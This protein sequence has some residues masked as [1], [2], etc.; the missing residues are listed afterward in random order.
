[1]IARAFHSCLVLA[2]GLEL[3]LSGVSWAAPITIVNMDGF[4]EGFNDSSPRSSIGGNPGTTLGAQRLY[5]FNHA[6]AIWSGILQNAVE[7]RVEARFDPQFCTATSAVL[8]S[9]GPVT[10]DIDFPG[11]EVADTWYVQALANKLAGTDRDPSN[12]DIGATFNSDVDNG[13]CLGSRDWYYG[14]DG[15]EGNHIELLP[16]VL[17]EIAHGLGFLTLV[18]GGNGTEFFGS[19]DIYERFMFDLS[20]DKHWP[21]MNDAERAASALNGGSLVWDGP[22]VTFRAQF[23]LA[24][25]A[26][27][28]VN[29]PPAIAGTRALGRASF[30]T[31]IG[32]PG[33]TR[34]V[35]LAND[36]SGV[37]SDACSALLNAAQ[38]S[39]K[40][41]LV[42][43]ST[44]CSDLQ[45]ATNVQAAGG[46]GIMIV[47]SVA[48]GTPPT[49]RGTDP[50][51]TLVA[52]GLKLADGNALRGELGNGVNVTMGEDPAHLSGAAD[53]GRV[54]LFAPNP[55]Q[56]GSSLSHWD[57]TAYPNLLMEPAI[58]ANLSSDVDLT[59]EH[60]EDIG[61]LPDVT[62]VGRPG[63]VPAALPPNTPNPFAATTLLRFELEH[64]G[65]AE[66]A[67]FDMSGRRIRQ[68]ARGWFGAGPHALAWDGRDDA[69]RRVK[70]GVYLHRLRSAGFTASRRMVLV[71]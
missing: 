24:R 53:N 48:A 12:N 27:L 11:A 68:V 46:A 16:V 35:V 10:V 30:G 25:R 28:T 52:G 47:D 50:S 67:V 63:G 44:S 6:A 51:I 18:D 41:A 1:M 42:D 49:L 22:A 45:R 34:D 38:V 9:A 2:F 20:I 31:P 55:L 33:L 23:V 19:P 66:L 65:L 5:V 26:Q 13:T 43:R 8:G 70:P 4:D 36:G 37:T 54:L 15:N 64:E 71:R 17:H 40:I 14:V 56:G 59:R 7:I 21:E 62:G 58:N 29:T 69:G 60:F 3:A 39:G 32:S 61:W 57:V